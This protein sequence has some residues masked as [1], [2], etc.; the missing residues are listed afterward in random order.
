[1]SRKIAARIPLSVLR[2]AQAKLDEV[3]NMLKPHL[4]TLSPPERQAMVKIG[5][6]SFKF[7]EMS[8]GIALENP[9][10][11][12]RFM[13]AAIRG[14]EFLIARELI[15]LAGKLNQLKDIIGDTE[16]TACNLALEAAMSFYQTIKIAARRDIPGAGLI[17]EELKPVKP[18]G[19]QI[20]GKLKRR[21]TVKSALQPELFENL[22]L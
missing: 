9:E 13:K 12:P 21:K 11:F 19:K 17:Y 6:R 8:S 14:E 20:P 3:M 4:I 5:E 15:S 2:D 7:I 18:S 16:M 1:M 22:Q 10:L